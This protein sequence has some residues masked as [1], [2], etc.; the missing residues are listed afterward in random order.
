MD[1]TKTQARALSGALK[2][3]HRALLKAEAGDDPAL[4][5]PY[6]MLFAIIGEDP[7][8][9]WTSIL[10]QLIVFLDEK[11]AEDE[12]KSAEDLRPFREGAEKL[13]GIEEGGEAEFRLRY[14]MAL[15][16]D[17]HVGLAAGRLRRTL[18]DMPAAP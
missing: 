5:N 7:R 6:T 9:K 17:P 16:K 8:F 13:M 12:M 11:L 3:L 1:E 18:K 15:Q 2:E 10:S 14:M 4:E